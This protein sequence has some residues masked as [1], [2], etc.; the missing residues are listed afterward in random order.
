MLSVVHRSWRV[1]IASNKHLLFN[2]FSLIPTN[3]WYRSA[4]S[5]T[6]T[7]EVGSLRERFQL[8]VFCIYLAFRTSKFVQLKQGKLPKYHDS[9]SLPFFCDEKPTWR[10]SVWAAIQQQGCKIVLQKKCLLILLRI[11]GTISSSVMKADRDLLLSCHSKT[12][13]ARC[14]YLSSLESWEFWGK[15]FPKSIPSSRVCRWIFSSWQQE[16][17]HQELIER[18]GGKK[19]GGK[20]KLKS[21]PYYESGPEREQSCWKQKLQFNICRRWD[22]IPHSEKRMFC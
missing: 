15:K 4:S 13:A 16:L 14:G 18:R 12:V 1:A 8:P 11:V 5:D 19:R 10:A 20:Q 7:E 3:P 6:E 21:K 9:R 17:L 2:F 22:F